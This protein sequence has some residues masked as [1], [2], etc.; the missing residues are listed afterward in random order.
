[1]KKLPD[2][3]LK[4]FYLNEDVMKIIFRYK[5]GLEWEELSPIIT[6][7]HYS[8]T[9]NK[10]DVTFILPMTLTKYFLLSK[11]SK[12]TRYI[13]NI[14]KEVYDEVLKMI[15]I[16]P[17]GLHDRDRI[18]ASDLSLYYINNPTLKPHPE[19]YFIVMSELREPYKYEKDYISNRISTGAEVINYSCPFIPPHW[20]SY[21][22]IREKVMKEKEAQD[23]N[24]Y[25]PQKNISYQQ[26]LADIPK[27]V[28]YINKY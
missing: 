6:R 27:K 22:G 24:Y 23:F 16:T 21:V 1:M 20:G 4:M 14:Y 17:P 18:T 11:I 15:K 7:P 5:A 28:N 8:M 3:T 13:Y 19:E 25:L 10:K 26:I 2:K 12:S 9:S